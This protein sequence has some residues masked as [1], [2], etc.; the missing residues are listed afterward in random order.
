MFENDDRA[1]SAIVSVLLAEEDIS[2]K[3]PFKISSHYFVF[4]QVVHPNK[5]KLNDTFSL[6]QYLK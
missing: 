5:N 6:G 2:S 1:N 4:P 3:K